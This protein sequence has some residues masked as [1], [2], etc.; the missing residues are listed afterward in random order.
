[1]P[2]AAVERMARPTWLI[3]LTLVVGLPAPPPLR[4]QDVEP[5]ESGCPP[6]PPPEPGEHPRHPWDFLLGL[7][8]APAAL[9]FLIPQ[10]EMED[11]DDHEL[12]RDG[13]FVS[14]GAGGYTSEVIEGETLYAEA[15]LLVGGLFL[16]GRWDRYYRGMR[17]TT[18]TPRVGYIARPRT[19]LAGGVV[20]GYRITHGLHDSWRVTGFEVD[21]PLFATLSRDGSPWVRLAPRY[22]WTPDGLTFGYVAEMW[23]DLPRTSFMIAPYFGGQ[24]FRGNDAI[25][26]GIKVGRFLRWGE[27]SP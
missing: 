22:A 3:A 11:F 8:F 5:P 21:I 26:L 24:N 20:I 13:L 14:A 23:F 25:V 27:P 18:L 17:A 2:L 10:C 7:A 16:E 19:G 9:A 12:S 15:S 4:A 6:P 1:M